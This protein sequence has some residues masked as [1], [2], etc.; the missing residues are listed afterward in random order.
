VQDAFAARKAL[1]KIVLEMISA[2]RIAP[3]RQ[4]DLLSL[5]FSAQDGDTGMGMSDNQLRSDHPIQMNLQKVLE[6]GGPA[7]VQTAPIYPSG[8]PPHSP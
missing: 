7:E 1:N 5:L 6:P 8:S 4:S 2:R 3:P